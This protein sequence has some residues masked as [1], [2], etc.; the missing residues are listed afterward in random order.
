MNRKHTTDV[1][2]NR[3]IRGPQKS[4]LEEITGR[5]SVEIQCTTSLKKDT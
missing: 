3:K 4:M 5:T 1:K 2:K